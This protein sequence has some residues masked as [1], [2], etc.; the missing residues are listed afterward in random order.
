[1]K[2]FLF[3]IRNQADHQSGWTQ[4]ESREFLEKCEH[5]IEGLKKHGKLIAAQPLARE[6]KTIS[7]MAGN[8]DENELSTNGEVVVGY[9][10]IRARD[11][12]EASD[13]ARG[14]PEFEMSTT[15][16]VEIRPIK[17]KEEATE[18]VYTEHRELM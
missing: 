2:E 17:V 16:R 3:L 14:N 8:W 12:E 4:E 11:L 7:G 5:Y 18:Y 9:Y 10:H 13:I 1:M 6:G 15:A